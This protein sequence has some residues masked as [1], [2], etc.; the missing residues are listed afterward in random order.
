VSHQLVLASASP[1][2]LDLLKQLGFS[3]IKFPV[4]IDETP[5]S[6]ELPV[7]YVLRMA[8]EKLDAAMDAWVA[9]DHTN[10]VNAD[11][12]VVLLSGDTVCIQGDEILVKPKDFA[13]FQRMMRNMSGNKHTVATSFALGELSD[14]GATNLH[15]GVVET[16]VHF[17]MISEDEIQS[18]W[19]TG[20][21]QDKAG[22]YGIQGLGAVF[23]ER[24]NGS[25]SNVVGLP[26][27]EVHQQLC[28]AGLS[29]LIQFT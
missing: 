26:L 9:Q 28:K 16:E 1:R 29:S 8:Q 14:T 4:E 27:L 5:K 10:S 7:D 25:Y 15:L 21:P 19:E 3:P 2:R 20:E 12:P 17:R 22:G 13:D 18:Y 6:G 23:V 11:S 24:I